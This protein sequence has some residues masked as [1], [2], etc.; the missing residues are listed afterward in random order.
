M[1]LILLQ[2]GL[3][4]GD[5]E[6]TDEV[7]GPG[8]SQWQVIEDHPAF[9]ELALD[10]EEPPPAPHDDEGHLDMTPL[11]DVCMVLL[12]FFILIT[13]V[14]ALQKQIEA[15]TT[16]EGKVTVPV[17]T[18]KQLDEQMIHVKATMV[19]GEPE[20]RM[21]GEVVPL[22]SLV[23]KLKLAAGGTK[24]TLLLEHDDFVT[25]EVVVQIIDQAKKAN[26]SRI[27]MVVK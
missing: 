2:Q 17:I 3:L 4:D 12:I 5:W 26:L 14:A 27:N 13:T 25:Q 10:I 16:S 8:E 21:E 7:Q 6:L 24:T 15:P 23:A 11:I 18:K 22:E 1:P 9:E 20:I 19:N